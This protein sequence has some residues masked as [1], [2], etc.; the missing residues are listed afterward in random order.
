VIDQ[1]IVP[2]TTRSIALANNLVY[3]GDSASIIDIFTLSAPPPTATVTL[4]PTSI[5]TVTPTR[6]P[7]GTPTLAPTNTPTRTPTPTSTPTLTPTQ[8][9]SATPSNTA[10]VTSTYTPTITP[11]AT[12]TRTATNTPT[13]TPTLTPTPT[14]TPTRTPSTTPSS[15]ATVT[16]TY[17]PTITPTAT[18]TRTATN[19]PT[20]TSTPTSTPTLTPSA[21]PSNTATATNTYTA[22]ITP[23]TTPT[24]TP[25]N[26][27]TNTPTLTSAPTSTPT[28]T[29]SVTPSNTATATSTNTR[30]I[31]PTATPTRTSTATPSST[32]SPTS[33]FTPSQTPTTTP[34]KTATASPSAT[35]TRTPTST[36]TPTATPTATPSPTATRTPTGLPATATPASVGVAGQI[37]YYSN[38]MPVSSA[39]VQLMAGST[40]MMDAQT[41]VSGQFN[42][43][44]V[45]SGISELVP[46]K[47][48][49]FGNAVGVLDA[50]D[51]LQASLGLLTLTDP[52]QLAC[53]VAGQGSVGVLDAVMILQHALGLM[54]TFPAAQAC[55]SDWAFLPQPATAPN[56]ALVQPA[57][58]PGICQLGAIAYQPLVTSA[59]NQNFA[60]VLFGDCSGQWQPSSLA[61]AARV[62]TTSPD[63]RL[64]RAVRHG[65]HV[66]LPLIVQTSLPFEGLEA[67]VTYDPAQLTLVGVAPQTGGPPVLLQ[68]NARVPGTVR[69]ALAS[70]LPLDNGAVV[71]LGFEM[72]G[73][74]AGPAIRLTRAVLAAK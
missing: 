28:R 11:T 74:T 60:A 52:Q 43:S 33:S 39:T 70:A 31:T 66:Y 19:T 45:D 15:T 4:T 73:R 71:R 41:D 36:W 24:R 29:P 46:Q 44:G 22:T 18:P 42:F 6:T 3:A 30:T 17:T 65:R 27:P 49:D 53:A 23:T 58:S 37:A 67:T 48:G 1:A 56:Q 69:I 20:L 68:T 12:P 5:P 55:G 51:A 50:V 40:N 9:P 57:L 25:T 21:T 47:S 34:T 63:V 10:T 38:G 8:T 13:S 16:S 35:P 64:G 2:G 7:T 72:K 62:S 59:N 61:P 32:A 26:T 14:A 54:D